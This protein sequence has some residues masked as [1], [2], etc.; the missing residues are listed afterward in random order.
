LRRFLA[1]EAGCDFSL[2]PTFLVVTQAAALKQLKCEQE[3]AVTAQRNIEHAR[4]VARKQLVREQQ[5]AA[6]ER[7]AMERQA[8]LAKIREQ[9]EAKRREEESATGLQLRKFST[10]AE[11]ER[12]LI[13]SLQGWRQEQQQVL[14][15]LEG[16]GV[17]ETEASSPRRR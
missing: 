15:K 3:D 12:R 14:R 5:R 4:C 1:A 6:Q 2:P 9:R 11:E 16:V 13:E 17:R 7:K 8:A 10:L